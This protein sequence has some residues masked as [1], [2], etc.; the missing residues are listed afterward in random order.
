M[1]LRVIWQFIVPQYMNITTKFFTLKLL[2]FSFFSCLT[3]ERS[4]VF[5]LWTGNMNRFREL[6][7]PRLDWIKVFYLFGTLGLHRLLTKTLKFSIKIQNF[8]NFKISKILKKLQI[9][10][11]FQNF[12]KISNISVFIKFHKISKLKFFFFKVHNFKIFKNF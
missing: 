6:L 5:R 9:F 4:I 1:A 11:R 12:L 8:K 3:I 7:V 10:I 2:F